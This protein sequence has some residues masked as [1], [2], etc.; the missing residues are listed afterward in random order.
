VHGDQVGAALLLTGTLDFGHPAWM[1]IPV[2]NLAGKS[3]SVD[4]DLPAKMIGAAATNNRV[5]S[6]FEVAARARP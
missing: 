3:T 1:E 6:R 5:I 4:T 2:N